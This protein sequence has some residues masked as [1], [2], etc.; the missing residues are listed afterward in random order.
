MDEMAVYFSSSHTTTVDITNRSSIIVK[1]TGFDSERM[2]CLLAIKPDGT[3]LKPFII[4][5]GAEDG[6]IVEKNGVFVTR[7][8]KAWI[9]QQSCK[10]WLKRAFPTTFFPTTKNKKKKKNEFTKMLVWDACPVHRA[11]E[12]KKYLKQNVFMINVKNIKLYGSFDLHSLSS[13]FR[14]WSQQI[15]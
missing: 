7:T 11:D 10:L 14:H 4:L 5:K 6:V 15:I 1:G 2:T 9:T 13:I 3:I 12:I 8:E